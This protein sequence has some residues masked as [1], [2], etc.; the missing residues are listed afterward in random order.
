MLN[1]CRNFGIKS[2]I[3]TETA[4]LFRLLTSRPASRDIILRAYSDQQTYVIQD[5]VSN[6]VS[7]RAS[8]QQAL[9]AINIQQVVANLQATVVH[10]VH[11]P[12]SLKHA[13]V[14]VPLFENPADGTIHVVLTQ[15]SA[16]LST[17]SG[18]VCFPGGK[19]DPQDEDDI[20]TALR[21][22]HE[23]LGINPNSVNVI[24][25]LPPVLSKHFLSVTPV[26]GVVQSDLAFTPNPH[27]VQ[28]VF[29]A[30]LAMFL[31]AGEGYYSKDLLWDRHINYRIHFWDYKFD[32]NKHYTIWGLTAGMLILVAEKAFQV[33]PQFEVHPPGA[34]PYTALAFE[35]GRLVFRG[36]GKESIAA[37]EEAQ[38]PSSA[39]I[40]GAT[41]TDEEARAAVGGC[42]EE[43]N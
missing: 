43:A 17:H 5:L 12:V 25:C 21:E 38:Q 24:C 42:E 23:E 1:L 22:A 11:Q 9:T 28:S 29:T 27:E 18:E 30:P 35:Q 31:S 16:K 37:A 26:I 14:L 19:R 7:T 6:M 4:T 8:R 15:R 34:P 41:V 39:A 3:S 40:E 13:A 2:L 32:E 33:V 36:H 20:A 10:Q